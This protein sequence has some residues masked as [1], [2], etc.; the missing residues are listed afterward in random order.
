MS[1][2]SFWHDGI[3]AD[4]GRSLTDRLT[5]IPRRPDVF[6]DGVRSIAALALRGWLRVYHR[7]AITG[8][9]DLPAAGS[10]VMVANHSSHLDA[11]CMLS[12]LPLRSLNR[13][14]P[15]AAE[16]YFFV[17]L[18]RVAEAAIFMNAMP[19]GRQHHVRQSMQLC[20]RLLRERGNILILF[21]EGTR[22]V[23]GEL[24][25]FRPGVGSLL[26]GLDVPVVPC[27]IRGTYRALPKGSFWPRPRRVRL[28]I[29]P[30]RCYADL[31]R[32]KDAARHIARELHD[33]V[34]ELLC[35]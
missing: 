9:E 17:S 21:P 3:A 18:P 1:Q 19:F 28:H 25:E 34:K 14:Y 13:A 26:A 7:F 15:A 35:D 11:L 5:D 29:G 8:L 24:A 16:D 22:S 27:A 20:R 32:G 6:V 23:D 33:A 4:V 30:S 31:G 12:A 2:W 10:F